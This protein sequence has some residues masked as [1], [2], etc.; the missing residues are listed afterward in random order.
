VAR[1]RPCVQGQ[2]SLSEVSNAKAGVVELRIVGVLERKVGLISSNS[3]QLRCSSRKLEICSFAVPPN[4]RASIAV[5]LI[6]IS[7]IE[8][9]TRI[10]FLSN[11]RAMILVET[12]CAVDD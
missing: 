1:D 2:M 10:S 5:R 4:K 8:L 6:D 12:I 3:C 11:W 9:S 7:V